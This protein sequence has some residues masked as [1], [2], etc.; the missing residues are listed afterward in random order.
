MTP[1]LWDF[2][3][4]GMFDLIFFLRVVQSRKELR[5]GG[6]LGEWFRVAAAFSE[7]LNEDLPDTKLL[8]CRW[9]PYRLIVLRVRFNPR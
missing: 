9:R 4:W 5:G 2:I 3:L 1:T 8:V 7:C 6:L